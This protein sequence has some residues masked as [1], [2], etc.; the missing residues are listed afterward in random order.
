MQLS[1]IRLDSTINTAIDKDRQQ[2]GMN[3]LRC[4]LH[5]RWHAIIGG[6]IAAEGVSRARRGWTGMVGGNEG[7]WC[8]FEG[9]EGVR[10]IRAEVGVDATGR[11]CVLCTS[12]QL[13]MADRSYRPADYSD[14]SPKQYPSSTFPRCA[15]GKGGN[16][17]G[18]GHL[19]PIERFAASTGRREEE[20]SRLNSYGHD[21]QRLP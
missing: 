3:V 19:H 9:D 14:A 12:T 15:G 10:V 20:P 2:W 11:Y 7:V 13:S 8:A 5:A 17:S 4:L 16:R 18:R 6:P 1:A 21:L